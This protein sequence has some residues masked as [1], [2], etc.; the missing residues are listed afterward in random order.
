MANTVLHGWLNLKDLANERVTTIGVDVVN[1]AIAAALEEHNRQ[2]NDL[3]NTFTFRTQAFKTRFQSVT[4]ARLQPL[5]DD[6]KARPIKTSGWYEIA[7]PMQAGGVAL[8][9]NRVT[10]EKITVGEMERQVQNLL[11]ADVRWTRDH[12]LAALYN[13]APWS[14]DDPF[15]GLL[16]VQPL[17][18]GDAI[19]Y[20][21]LTGADAPATDNH[22]L[23]QAAAI[24]DAS[25][26]FPLI[27]SKLF[28][29][30][31]NEGDIV[32]LVPSNLMPSIQ[33]L[34]LYREFPDVNIQYA[35]TERVLTS[36]GPG[37]D[38]PGITRGYVSRCWI[39]EWRAMPNDYMIGFTA[40][41]DAPLAM[42]EEPEATLSGGFKPVNEWNMN[43]HYPFWE[44]QY[45]RR[46]GF[47]A[48]NRIG[49]V[50]MRIGNAAY[51]TPAGYGSPMP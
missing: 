12:I 5:D 2:L 37:I 35:S 49:A 4:N 8:G 45:E 13:A 23:A 48:W 38:V 29:H 30:P 6:G 21:T 33:G 20:N 36:N 50:V 25:N 7:L 32:V 22:L 27:W 31:E 24:A 19:A 9:S 11:M 28:E 16:T 39:V 14:Y 18:N 40:Q 10:R 44:R 43:D 51:A 3:I 1:T 46:C 26:P 47:G 41:G 15:H 17:A 42:R 34:S